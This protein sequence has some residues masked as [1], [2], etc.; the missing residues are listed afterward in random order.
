M[1]LLKNIKI[2]NFRG[3]DNLEVS[4]LNQINLFIGNNNSGKSAILEAIFLLIGI[5]N[6]MLPENIN[7]LR[8][9]NIKSADDFKYLFHKL[10]HENRPEFN[11]TFS[12]ESNRYLSLNYSCV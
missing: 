5:S 2:K 11:G 4:D 7:R 1:D 3:F 12:D 6:P 8:G 10:K 9:L